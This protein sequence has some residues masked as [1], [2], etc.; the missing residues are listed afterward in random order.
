ML[1]L[2]YRILEV[3]IF[4]RRFDM[5]HMISADPQASRLV[6]CETEGTVTAKQ[7]KANLMQVP[8]KYDLLTDSDVV[9][10]V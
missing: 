2:R 8:L 7:N 1:N 4:L 3:A 6:E 5:L 9:L 10:L